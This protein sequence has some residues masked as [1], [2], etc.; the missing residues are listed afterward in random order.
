MTSLRSGNLEN[1][2]AF[3]PAL[4]RLFHQARHMGMLVT[5]LPKA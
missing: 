2:V 1:W 5:S 4:E 3:F